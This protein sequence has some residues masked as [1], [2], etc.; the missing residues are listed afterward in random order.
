[1][2]THFE[3]TLKYFH[4]DQYGHIYGL[5]KN[6]T[7]A[8]SRVIVDGRYTEATNHEMS[9]LAASVDMYEALLQAELLAEEACRNQDK[10]NQCWETLK[11]IRKALE[12]AGRR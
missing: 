8:H 3:E 11:T 1:M 10:G 7:G 9:M 6:D 5:V 4:R 12:K 2:T